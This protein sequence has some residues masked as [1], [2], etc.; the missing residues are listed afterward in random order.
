LPFA[1]PRRRACGVMSTSSTCSAAGTT[2]SGTVSRC[3]TPVMWERLEVVHVD[4]GEHVDAGVEQ[5]LHV[6]EPLGVP[7]A[8][9]V[10]V[11]EV[12]DDGEFGAMGQ[13]G[14]EIH[15]RELGGP[16]R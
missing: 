12:I 7:G 3:C 16:G 13:H 14:V 15:L 8:G 6:L 1:I 4:G 2:A 9:H 10:G 11:S 5:D